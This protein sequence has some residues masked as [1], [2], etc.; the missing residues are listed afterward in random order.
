M[1]S[2]SRFYNL[3]D[4]LL[5]SL[6]PSEFDFLRYQIRSIF[7]I[8]N[9]S[10]NNY[11]NSLLHY[12][13][14]LFLAGCIFPIIEN[15]DIE[16]TSFIR[17]VLLSFLLVNFAILFFHRDK[18]NVSI[19]LHNPQL[20]V[21]I[22]DLLIIFCV[23]IIILVTADYLFSLINWIYG[24]SAKFIF[25]IVGL[26]FYVSCI[27]LSA[28]LEHSKKYIL[29]NII[30]F[31]YYLVPTVNIV[32]FIAFFNFEPFISVFCSI[33]FLSLI[34]LSEE[35]IKSSFLQ[36]IR[37][38][39]P[40]LALELY[41]GLKRLYN[42][43]T[44]AWL[45]LIKL[46]AFAG[47]LVLLFLLL[48]SGIYAINA[49]NYPI[50]F[51]MIFF[52]FLIFAL[53]NNIPFLLRYI[54]LLKI[55]DILLPD[56]N[57]SKI[58][59]CFILFYCLIAFSVFKDNLIRAQHSNLSILIY[60]LPLLMLIN[61]D[62]LLVS[63]ANIKDIFLIIFIKII[64]TVAFLAVLERKWL[65]VNSSFENIA[66]LFAAMIL[67]CP[68]WF[69]TND[70][71]EYLINKNAQNAVKYVEYF[72]ALCIVFIIYLRQRWSVRLK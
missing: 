70:V 62:I 6:I 31:T 27:L 42:A 65:R 32:F 7:L 36:Q 47:I 41:S 16:Y 2:S 3:L 53:P 68:N 40:H 25:I 30:A 39:K 56:I 61:H 9:V 33:I 14:P 48:Y 10:E 21:K 22:L 37:L 55:A 52:V 57:Q 23:L 63:V 12:F 49:H 44:K 60:L 15:L 46:V 45:N 50:I 35:A 8:N 67:F 38:K 17:H 43:N 19:L 20:Y 69:L 24:D 71:M 58:I 54:F 51:R 26:I 59:F 5:E 28:W 13:A 4:K 11:E 29:S 72:P 34:I 66:L 64:A 1:L 18:I